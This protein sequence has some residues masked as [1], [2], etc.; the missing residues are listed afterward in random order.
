[1]EMRS[2]ADEPQTGAMIALI[3]SPD[4]AARLVV[5]G[6]EKPE[7]L[8][9]TLCYWADAVELGNP[10]LLDLHRAAI[11]IAANFPAL[12]GE[13]FGFA[14]FNPGDNI[15][16]VLEI[17][18]DDLDVVRQGLVEMVGTGDSPNPWNAHMTLKYGPVGQPTVSDKLGPVQFTHIRVGVGDGYTEYPLSGEPY[19]EGDSPEGEDPSLLMQL[20]E[21]VLTPVTDE[22]DAAAGHDDEDWHYAD[23]GCNCDDHIIASVNT[24]TWSSLPVAPRETPWSADDAIARISTWAGGNGNKF[25]SPFLWKAKDGQPLNPDSY[26]L[27]VA[28]VVN[29]RL[30]LIPRAVFSAGTILSGGH[31]YLEGVVTEPEREALKSTV[32]DIYA[33]L[34]REYQDPRVV[35]PWLRGRTPDEREQEASDMSASLA[36]TVNSSE[37]P[38]MPIADPSR[39]WDSDAARSRVREWADGDMRQYRRAFV[40]RDQANPENVGA[41]KL[42]I[43]DV[44]DG[45]LQIVP[46]SVSAALG[47]IEGARGGVAIPDDDMDAVRSVL[48]GIRERIDSGSHTAA[49]PAAVNAPPKA[50][51]DDPQLTGPTPLTVT[52]D[53][54]VYGHLAAWGVCHMGIAD[55]CVLAPRSRTDYKYFRNGTVLTSDGS[56]IKVGR[57]TVGTGHADARLGYI[58]AADHYDNTGTATA[59]VVPREDKFGISLAGGIVSDASPEQVAALRRSPLSGDWRRTREGGLELVAAL[60]VNTPGYPII[61]RTASGEPASLLAAGLVLPDGVQ[62]PEDPAAQIQSRVADLMA[63]IEARIRQGRARRFA[64]IAAKMKG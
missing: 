36:A 33:M 51:F 6:G 40:W 26:R 30:T 2:V 50:W 58:P 61:S 7:D 13:A 31:G 44:I 8:H 64:E 10:Y 29:G 43:A 18:G 20:A 21:S 57:V 5:P 39:G 45:V 41:Y 48:Q 25:G 27:P 28:D 46:K 19:T 3:P 60:A 4:D 15:C 22:M 47:A 17:N 54:R 34:Q 35:A 42:P 62:M 63:K 23:A 1:M 52:A 16:T 14:V 55:R 49:A 12:V 11:S 38:S 37:W 9:V 59:V 53:G 56:M 24:K 32:T